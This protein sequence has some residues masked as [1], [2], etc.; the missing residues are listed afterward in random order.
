[1]NKKRVSLT[2]GVIGVLIAAACVAA[3]STAFHTP[4]YTY[5][6]EQQSNKMGFLPTERNGFAYMSE[7]GCNLYHTQGGVLPLEEPTV[8]V[9]CPDT[10]EETCDTCSSTCWNTCWSTCPNT[11]W[12]TCEPTCWSTC[13]EPTCWNT[14]G[15]ACPT[16]PSKCPTYRDCP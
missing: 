4:L 16:S 6:M 7:P 13:E 12:E 1:M 8:P 3:H 14:C 11:C 9:T 15:A 2:A 10:C 5:R